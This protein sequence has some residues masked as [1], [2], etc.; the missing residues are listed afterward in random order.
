MFMAFESYDLS[1]RTALITGSAGILGIQHAS[2]LLEAGAQVFLTDIRMRDLLVAKEKL[3]EKFS[4]HLIHICTMDVTDKENI[5]ETFDN[6]KTEK[7]RIDIFEKY[8]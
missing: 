7:F 2:A 4:D 5:H 6:L 3:S 1:G 8:I